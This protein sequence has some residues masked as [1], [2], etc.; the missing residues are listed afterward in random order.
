MANET[1]DYKTALVRR[2]DT[3]LE[4]ID[5]SL[6]SHDVKITEYGKICV[7]NAISAINELMTAEGLTMESPT[8]DSG[9]LTT[10]LLTVATLELNAKATNREIYFILRNKSVKTADG[11]SEWK[12][13]I[14]LNIEGDA[15]DT[16]LA[17]FG[18]NVKK[19][20][21]Y[22]VVHEG[23]E[24]IYPRMR[25]LEMTP[26]EW[27]ANGK[28]EKIASVVYPIIGTDNTSHFYIHERA[29]VATSI[30]A[31]IR[32]NLMNET[33]GICAD[34]YKATDEQKKQIAAKKQEIM[35]KIRNLSVDEILACPDVAQY[36]SDAW[37]ESTEEMILRKL[38]NIACKK[39]PKD[40][41]TNTYVREIY[42][43]ANDPIYAEAVEVID[44]NAGKEAL[45]ESGNANAKATPDF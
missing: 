21:P 43:R 38:R 4:M 26:H 22:W 15:N 7:V 16:L 33:F 8:V 27:Q 40:F 28:S 45:P 18:R 31:H 25:G 34:R 36:I 44:D 23:D 6:A 11:K 13:Q 39:I 12:K 3:Y 5:K 37:S 41:G 32:N 14:E 20:C 2:N 30:R 9:T 19:V 24:F 10:A 1:K 35:D 17:K 29:E 42:E